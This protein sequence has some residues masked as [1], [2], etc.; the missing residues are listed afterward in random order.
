MTPPFL[1]NCHA[2]GPRAI[3]IIGRAGT[4]VKGKMLQLQ[5]SVKGLFPISYA[6]ISG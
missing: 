2:F 4:S 3:P 5:Q 1:S 6:I